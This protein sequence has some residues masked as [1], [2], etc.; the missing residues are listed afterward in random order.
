MHF[1]SV[2][3]LAL[4]GNFFLTEIL[5]PSLLFFKGLPY[6]LKASCIS[7]WCPMKETLCFFCMIGAASQ[8]NYKPVQFNN[9]KKH[10]K[11]KGQIKQMGEFE[12]MPC[13]SPLSGNGDLHHTV[14]QSHVDLTYSE[15]IEKEP[16]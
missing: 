16:L 1:L 15:S 4:E 13:Y 3:I 14:L 6:Q 2:Q 7:F 11:Y 8:P 5:E 12:Q 9:I 10:K